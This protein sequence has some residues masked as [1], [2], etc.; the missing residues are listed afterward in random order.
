MNQQQWQTH[1]RAF[2]KSS[3]SK[4]AYSRKHNLNYS[5]FLYWYR[6]LSEQ[7]SVSDT[8]DFVPVAI[9]SPVATTGNLGILEF[10]NGI[11]LVINS[12]VLLAQIPGLMDL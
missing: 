1:I 8:P 9:K 12:P 10:P 6:K 7:T 2:E 5:Q 11:K 4:R 3:Q